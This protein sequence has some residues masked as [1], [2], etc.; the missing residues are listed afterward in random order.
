ML[1]ELAGFGGGV[2]SVK[3]AKYNRAEILAPVK[4]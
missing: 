3:L 1:L 4:P 2:D